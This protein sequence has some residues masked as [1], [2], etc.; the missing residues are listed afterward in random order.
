MRAL[1]VKVKHKVAFFGVRFYW[2]TN[3]L[4]PFNTNVQEPNP[5]RVAREA[6][7]VKPALLSST[8]R[9]CQPNPAH[10]AALAALAALEALG[11]SGSTTF[12]PSDN[13]RA[14][15]EGSTRALVP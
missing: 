8:Q 1:Q 14:R 9:A 4:A 2:A 6:M 11:A 5:Q 10:L 13:R 15:G 3:H 12:Q 7:R